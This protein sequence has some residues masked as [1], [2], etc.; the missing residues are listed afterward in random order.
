M[1]TVAEKLQI[2][3]PFVLNIRIIFDFIHQPLIYNIERSSLC[4]A[5]VSNPQPTSLY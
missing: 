2:S 4:S 5:W 1:C 3:P